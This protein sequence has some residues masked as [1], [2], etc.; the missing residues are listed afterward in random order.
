MGG[1]PGGAVPGSPRANRA[2]LIATVVHG[3]VANHLLRG[4]AYRIGRE[5]EVY[6]VP[7]SGGI[8]L[9]RRIG[10]RAM[11]VAADHLEPGV[12]LRNNDREVV[13]GAGA[14]NRAFMALSCI[15]NRAV[16]TTGPA[17]GAVGVVTGKHGG[18]NHVIVDFA[19]AVKR[20]M[21]IGDRVQVEAYGQGLRLPELPELRCLNLGPGLLARWGLRRH[22]R[23]LHAPVTHL[24]P[25]GLLGSGLGRS[26][27]VLGDCDIQ[28]SDPAVRERWRL[29]HLRLGDLV[30][31]MPVNFAHG[32]SRLAGQ[33][34]LG[35]IVHGDS[36]VAGH[37]P[38]F[39]PLIMGPL[40]VLRPGFDPAANLALVLGRR[41]RIAP[42]PPP[43][44]HEHA[45]LRE[46]LR[47]A[48]G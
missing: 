45:A 18:I 31:V 32:P 23:H 8:C 37:G 30:A 9:N 43:G 15:G 3:Q 1:R 40:R 36:R 7:G 2:E 6:L 20:R 19:P 46:R 35:V 25:A 47:A 22:G 24:I 17:A 38:G 48:A 41:D 34:T 33:V 4:H 26:D 16:V 28:L 10:D 12:S 29:D 21:R 27:G 39:T 14:A 42:L 13:G 11:G 44:E 5:G